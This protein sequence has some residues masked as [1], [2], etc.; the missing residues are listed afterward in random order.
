MGRS[1][2][3]DKVGVKKGPWTPEED[4]MLVSY[5]QQHGSSGF[6]KAVP[7]N[8]GL[9]R[10]SK[11]CRLRWT[12]Y[13]KPGIKRGNFTVEEEMTIIQL[14]SLL[15]NKW[16]VIASYL[17][18]RTDNDIKNYWNSH[19][20]RKPRK[21]QTGQNSHSTDGWISSSSSSSHSIPKGKWE[22]SLQTDIDMPKQ[23]LHESLSLSLKN[24]KPSFIVPADLKPIP[25]QSSTTLYPLNIDNIARL[26]KG[27]MKKTPKHACKTQAISVTTDHLSFNSTSITS[28]SNMSSTIL[29]ATTK[30]STGIDLCEPFES[31]FGFESLDSSN[32]NADVSQSI[33]PPEDNIFQCEMKP[34]LCEQ[35]PFSM[36]ENWFLDEGR[37][38]Q[39]K[40]EELSDM[41][42]DENVD[43]F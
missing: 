14:Q 43:L 1:P 12:N 25:S 41:G 29:S 27:W 17:P 26:L 22:R 20:K 16:S 11:S 30:G 34:N 40:E 35:V 36:P 9:R 39:G 28:A 37:A 4:I 18:D 15:G 31:L 13:L 8:T 42:L 24:K 32:N 6:W 10:C 23:A 33:T 38:V 19:L 7:T 21:I 2:C 3:C 5:I